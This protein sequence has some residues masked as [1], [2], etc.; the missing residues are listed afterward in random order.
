VDIGEKRQESFLNGLNDERTYAFKAIDFV[1]F[2]AI[3]DKVLVLENRRGMIDLK[4][5]L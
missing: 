2:P 5:K 4:H 3:V 1:N